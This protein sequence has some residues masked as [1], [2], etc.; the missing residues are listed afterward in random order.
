MKLFVKTSAIAIFA[1]GLTVTAFAQTTIASWDFEKGTTSPVHG[2]GTITAIGSITSTVDASKGTTSGSSTSGGVLETT[3]TLSGYALS[4]VNYPTQG[5]SEKTAGVQIA[6]STETYKNIIL[7]FD[8]RH[9]NKCSNT[10][11]LQYTTNGTDWIDATS[12]LVSITN[13]TW[14]LRTYDFTSISSVNNNANFAIRL[15]SAFASGTSVYSPSNSTSTYD[16][17]KGYRFDN[18]TFTGT[19][20]TSGLKSAQTINWKQYGRTLKFETKTSNDIEIINA[21]GVTIKKFIPSSE[22]TLDLPKGIYIVKVGEAS[23]KIILQ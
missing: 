17:T 13:D 9:G 12:F 15:V 5:T 14:F 18:I 1:L 7:T 10:M 16:T 4:T 11:V 6:L 3:L 23:K 21:N 8:A 19:P 22:V 20:I 2:S